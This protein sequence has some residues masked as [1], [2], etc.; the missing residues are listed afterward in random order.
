M[1]P[2]ASLLLV[3]D[4]ASLGRAGIASGAVSLGAGSIGVFVGR[5]LDGAHARKVLV[6]LTVAHGPAIALL[7]VLAGSKNTLALLGAAALAGGTV[8]PVGPIVRA[9][10]A[11][12]SDLQSTR[13][14]FA[15]EA[16]SVEV[17]WIGGPLLVSLAVFL[18]GADIAVALSPLF[19]AIGVAA[20]LRQ[21]VR[22]AP[23]SKA[24]GRWIGA[25]LVRL[26]LAFALVGT[27]FRATTIAIVEVA[28]LAGH[29][30][31]SGTLIA[32]WA[33]GSLLG[34]WF[35]ARR[36]V[37][38]TFALGIGLAAT[39]ALVGIGY[40][41]LF[42]TGVLVVLTGLPTAPFISGVNA[43][44]STNVPERAHARAFAAMQA[45]ATIMAAAGAAIGGVVIER[46]GPASVSVPAGALVLVAAVL[47]RQGSGGFFGQKRRGV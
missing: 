16:M 9:I 31:Q 35:A 26:V 6:G 1:L 46:F 22:R 17:T 19:A 39:L 2:I 42:L 4:R 41:N 13:Q 47:A 34:G 23:I 14:S 12:R 32:L 24:D 30:E 33:L 11:Q 21:P 40:S 8:P 38:S 20:V 36:S 44:V 7:L 3:A 25:Q 5:H 27:A 10:L 15:Y 43:L 29:D 37:P 18:R 28:R 45:G